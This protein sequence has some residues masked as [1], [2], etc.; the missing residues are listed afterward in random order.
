ME[1]IIRPYEP[2]TDSGFIFGT[3]IKG[4]YNAAARPIIMSY[5]DFFREFSLTFKDILKDSTTLIACTKETPDFNVGYS[6]I[7]NQELQWVYVKL[8]FR[9]QGI[10]TLLTKNKDITSVNK[11]NL[12]RVGQLIMHNHESAFRPKYNMKE[13]S[14]NESNPSESN[15]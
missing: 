15:Q 6:I 3:I 12:T 5:D 2:D 9:M 8:S 4:I 10:A 11:K 13:E 1:I 7:H 14:T